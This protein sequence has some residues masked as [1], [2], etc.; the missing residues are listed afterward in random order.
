MQTTRRTTCLARNR[1]TRGFS[2]V[3]LLVVIG[4]IAI[5][6]GLLLPM[7]QRAR[8]SARATQCA[9]RLR[10][11]GNGLRLYS[12]SFKDNVPSWSGWQTYGGD[13]TGDDDAGLAWT[14]QL[15]RYYTKPSADG[16]QCPS[17][18]EENR[19]NYFLSVRH[20]F[21]NTRKSL[22][23]G[24]IRLSSSF[25]IAGDCTQP[26][27]YPPVFG[28]ASSFSLDDADK[29]DASQKGVLFKG[30]PDGRNLHRNGNNLLF[31]DNHV[32]LMDKPELQDVTYHPKRI[33]SW[34]SILP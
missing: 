10:E 9:S 1:P 24:E 31:G 6:I 33:Q 29:D 11:L 16:Y 17:F 28:V 14:E 30:E 32:S 13:G 5:L 3:E 34:E 26:K 7:L 15:E 20:Q 23:F 19:F 27:L 4:I 21:L 8:E 2:L 25:V 18:P 22:R 12:L